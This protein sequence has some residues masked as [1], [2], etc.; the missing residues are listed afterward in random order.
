MS[1]EPSPRTA[2]LVE[3]VGAVE[4]DLDV[5]VVHLGQA[6]RLGGVDERAVRG[7]LHADAEADR[8]LEQL[9]EV[10]ADHRFAA[11]DVD[12]EHLQGLQLVEHGLGFVGGQLARVAAPR[13]RQAVDALEVAGVRELPGETDGG[14]EAAL[15]LLDQCRRIATHTNISES[16]REDSARS[17]DGQRA[18][19]MS[20]ARRVSASGVVTV[21]RLH[22]AYDVRVFEEDQLAIAVVVRKRTERL[23]SQRDLGVQGEVTVEHGVGRQ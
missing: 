20:H 5:E 23:R 7:E 4:A 14:V 16:L 13:R 6:L 3:R 2:S 21:E 17:N 9:E 12:V 1:Y 22:D 11:A 15:Q 10:A 18:S 8:V 19:S